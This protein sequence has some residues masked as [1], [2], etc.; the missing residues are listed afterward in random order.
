VESDVGPSVSKR[1]HARLANFQDMTI[2]TVKSAKKDF[3]ERFRDNAS[4][5]S[6]LAENI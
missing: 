5:S 6:Y 3:K 2:K 4:A 1:L